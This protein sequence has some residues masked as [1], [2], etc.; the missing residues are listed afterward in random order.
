LNSQ[1]GIRQYYEEQYKERPGRRTGGSLKRVHSNL[2]GMH[3]K[4][5]DRVI[6]I[7]CGLGTTGSYLADRGAIPFGIDISYGAARAT[8]QSGGYAATS[9]A[10]AECLPFAD[11]SFDGAAFMGTL[12]HFI[13]PAEALREANRVLKPGA[14]ICFVVPNSSFFLFKFFGGTGQP[15]EIPRT[16]KGWRQLFE[17]E[18]LRVETVYRDVGPG[19]FDGGSLLRGALRRFVLFFSNLLP[20]H[21]TY[22]F[23]F[24]CHSLPA[25]I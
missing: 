11:L 18:G 6:D 13:D 12:E 22:Q 19:V 15:H 7:G 8:F 17:R 3:I 25:G 9:Q 4:R 21:Y 23:V 20:I 14:K 24:I 16:C 5:G 10:N 1:G 2:R